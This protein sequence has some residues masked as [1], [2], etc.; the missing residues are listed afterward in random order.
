MLALLPPPTV[1]RPAALPGDALRRR[2]RESGRCS[3]RALRQPLFLAT[4]SELILACRIAR[5]PSPRHGARAAHLAPC[6]DTNIAA[7]GCRRHSVTLPS[8]RRFQGPRQ[9]SR[10]F[11]KDH[12]SSA[13][14]RQNRP[15]PAAP[16]DPQHNVPPHRDSVTHPR[17]GRRERNVHLAHRG[18]TSKW[19]RRARAGQQRRLQ[20]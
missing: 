12:A 10:S 5:R 1:G 6:F 17:D 8:R 13:V 4:V 14:G 7:N 18:K 20:Q 15:T 16:R 11:G 3:I 9:W 19:R 2:T